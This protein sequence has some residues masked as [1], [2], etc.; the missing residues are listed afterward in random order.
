MED[1]AYYLLGLFG[2]SMPLTHG[3]GVFCPPFT[4]AIKAWMNRGKPG[5]PR[6]QSIYLNL[7]DFTISK[8]I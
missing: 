3:E 4:A 8:L 6:V 1:R 2:V 5:K 7:Q